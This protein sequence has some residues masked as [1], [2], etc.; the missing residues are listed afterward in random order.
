VADAELGEVGT[1]AVLVVIREIPLT[2]WEREGR[3][4]GQRPDDFHAA[5]MTMGVSLLTA[6]VMNLF[7]WRT[8]T[9]R[10][11]CFIRQSECAS[12]TDALKDALT[13]QS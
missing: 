2:P 9:G 5:V 8:P 11:G 4:K 13:P 12:A 6:S 1:D 7:F 10:F 3:S